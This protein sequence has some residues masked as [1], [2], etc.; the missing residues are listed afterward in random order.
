[1]GMIPWR[2]RALPVVA[3]EKLMGIADTKQRKRSRIV[4]FYPLPGCQPWE[5]FGVLTTN[6]PQSAL[7][8]EETDLPAYPQGAKQYPY[9]ATVLQINERVMIIPDMQK[10]REKLY[11]KTA[12]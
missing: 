10:L 3:L 5:F 4:V 12:P 1:M 2:K 8:E 11:P 9:A 7:I 6:E